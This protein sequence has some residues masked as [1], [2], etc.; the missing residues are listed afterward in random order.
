MTSKIVGKD[1]KEKRKITLANTFRGGI[2]SIW[3]KRN[4]TRFVE[5]LKERTGFEK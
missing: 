5:S 1:Q 2:F 4:T 3:T